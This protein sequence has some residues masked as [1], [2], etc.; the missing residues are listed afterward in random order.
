MTKPTLVIGNKNYSSWSM[1]GWLLLRGFGIDFDEVQLKFHTPGWRE[2]I[3][4]WS[5]SGLVPVLWLDGEPVWDT[6]SLAET[7]AEHWPEKPVWPR[8]AR[9]RALA[10]SISAEMHAGFH[11]LRAAMPMNIRGS[12]P[13]RGMSSE[14]AKDIDRIVAIWTR[15]RE[16]VGQGGALLFGAFSAADAFYAPVATR[17]VTYGVRVPDV[18][19][20]YV[21]AVLALPVV[22]EW[23]AAARA[24]P[25]VIAAEE[26]YAH[27]Y[28]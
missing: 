4:R 3:G 20:R 9:E 13:G 14:V 27:H 12:Y 11:A 24:E 17:F 2:N 1:R 28:R 26:P 6:V 21:D 16:R 8:D 19:K 25:E 18:A 23:S 15:C 22:Q 5:P 7:V 10:R